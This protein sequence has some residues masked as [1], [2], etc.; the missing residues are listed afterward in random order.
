[1]PRAPSSPSLITSTAPAA[2]AHA[3]PPLRLVLSGVHP[4]RPSSLNAPAEALEYAYPV[5]LRQYSF[6]SKSGGAGL[7]AGGDGIVREIEVLTAAQVT[8]LADRR[9]RGPYGL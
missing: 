2:R 3:P 1:M 6:R 9:S 7:H 4:H 8:L 5:R